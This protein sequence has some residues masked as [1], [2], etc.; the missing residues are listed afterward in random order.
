MAG[1]LIEA[2]RGE[3]PLPGARE[4]RAYAVDGFAWPRIAAR[5]RAVYDEAVAG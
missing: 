1:S 4:C 5:V 3:R 2:L